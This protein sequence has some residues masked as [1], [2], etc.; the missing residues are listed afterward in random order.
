MQGATIDRAH[1]LADGGGRELAY[2]AMSRARDT[3]HIYAVADND[4]QAANDLTREWNSDRR[5]RWVIDSDTPAVDDG[6]RR[7]HL[8]RQADQALRQA[9]L[10]AER[11][12]V[13]LVA[14]NATDRLA[15]LYVQLRLE[16]PTPP[17][18]LSRDF[19]IG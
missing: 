4:D 5:Q 8:H 14:P 2:V 11:D 6:A 13:Q 10:R 1:V 3:T 7:P 12:A 18:G 9:R 17:D 15:A 16:H 19:G